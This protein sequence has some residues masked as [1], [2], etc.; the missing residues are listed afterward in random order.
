MGMSIGRRL[1]L[2]AFILGLVLIGVAWFARA[3]LGSMAR[4]AYST[5][6]ISVPQ[7]QRMAQTELNVTRASLQ[8][9]HAILA[10][11]PQEQAAALAEIGERRQ[12]I[13]KALQDYADA[14][15]GEGR[16]LFASIPPLVAGFWQAGEA[17]LKLIQDGQKAEAF[18]YLVDRTIPARN[19]LL[20]ALADS[21][22]FQE[23]QLRRDLSGI[24]SD[25]ATTMQVLIGL[26]IGTMVGLGL[27][28]WYI[29]RLLRSRVAVSRKVAERVRDGDLTVAVHDAHRDEFSPLLAALRDMQT[30]LGRVVADVR[31]SAQSVANA[32]VEISQGNTDLSQRTEQQAS[33]LQ[34]TAASMEQLGA[35]VRQ[36]AESA[37]QA[38]QLAQGASSVAQQGGAVVGEVVQTMRG[39][40]DSSRKI[41]DIIS[42]IDSIA[43]Q[44]NILALN[45]AVEAARAGEQ[46]RGFAVVASE[47]RSLAGRSADAA[48]EIKS[49]ISASVDRVE[50]GSALVDQAGA[51]MQEIVGAIQRVTDI[52]GE[53]T[54]ASHEQ[55]AGVS[56]IGNAVMQMDQATQQNAALVEQS[57]AAAESLST[58]AQHLV[59]AMEV[60]KL[61]GGMRAPMLPAPR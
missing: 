52:M 36:N 13:D 41:V 18:A 14:S 58:Q 50:R 54:S 48:K 32:S 57:A 6:N 2:V 27:F 30:S 4:S 1:Y 3:E 8:L 40:N 17:N 23:E 38:N 34:T 44:T 42:V 53:I 12:A 20:T 15:S 21:V 60:F 11:N 19:L 10:R 24:R 59:Q 46:G 25:S 55:S 9:R 49:L 5:E 47:V 37:R 39:I 43:F 35:T 31:G 51:T 45:A 61:T 56:Q 22:R 28:A 16:T 33:T 29:S 7:L 26:V